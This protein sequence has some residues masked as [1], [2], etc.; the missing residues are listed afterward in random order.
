MATDDSYELFSQVN[1]PLGP[2]KPEESA[3]L[4]PSGG[5]RNPIET[6]GGIRGVND[7]WARL[8]EGFRPT[9]YE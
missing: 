1:R 2:G 9:E 7:R 6:D 5:S 8:V 3:G 4:A